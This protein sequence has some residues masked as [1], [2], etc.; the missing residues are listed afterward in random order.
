ME[1]EST[2]KLCDIS[3]ENIN[4]TAFSNQEKLEEFFT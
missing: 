1:N 2:K 4:G 3:D